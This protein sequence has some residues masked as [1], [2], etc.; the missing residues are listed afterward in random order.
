MRLTL[1][2]KLLTGRSLQEE[3]AVVARFAAWTHLDVPTSDVDELQRVVLA[4]NLFV[5]QHVDLRG[6]KTHR[7]EHLP[8]SRAPMS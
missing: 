1:M 6:K 4:E 8:T 3:D 5:A 7:R 2:V